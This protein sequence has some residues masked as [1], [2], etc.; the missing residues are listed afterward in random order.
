M[1]AVLTRTADCHL[2][3][4]VMFCFSLGYEHI[5]QKVKNQLLVLPVLAKYFVQVSDF[6][7][8]E[9]R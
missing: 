9:F 8:D 3:E 5:F 7:A 2:P 1:E 4:H 6:Y